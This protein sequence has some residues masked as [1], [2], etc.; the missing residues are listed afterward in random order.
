M[1]SSTCLWGH[2]FSRNHCPRCHDDQR[3]NLIG[4]DINFLDAPWSGLYA[5]F[6]TGLIPGAPAECWLVEEAKLQDCLWP[7]Q[8]TTEEELEVQVVSLESFIYA[9]FW[10]HLNGQTVERLCDQPLCWNPL[11]LQTAIH[12]SRSTPTAIHPMVLQRSVQ[13]QHVAQ[14]LKATNRDQWSFKYRQPID[15]PRNHINVNL[16]GISKFRPAPEFQLDYKYD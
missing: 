11:H 5:A 6:F 10:G 13:G 3:W 14:R 16:K 2:A 1:G 15:H 8:W 7:V 4:A 9:F 12:S